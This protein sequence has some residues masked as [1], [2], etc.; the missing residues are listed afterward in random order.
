MKKRKV[1]IYIYIY[2]NELDKLKKAYKNEIK[3]END[4]FLITKS[5][6]TTGHKS[7]LQSKTKGQNNRNSRNKYRYYQQGRYGQYNR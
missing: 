2:N 1:D 3:N 6:M 4:S 5:E 7:K